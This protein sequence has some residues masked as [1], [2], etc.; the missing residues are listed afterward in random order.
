[1]INYSDLED[2][3]FISYYCVLV[4]LVLA[5]LYIMYSVDDPELYRMHW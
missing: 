3:A 4:W 1:M 2:C 5:W